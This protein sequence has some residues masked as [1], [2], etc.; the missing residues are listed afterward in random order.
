MDIDQFKT[1]NDTMGHP[2]GDELLFQALLQIIPAAGEY[3]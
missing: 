1:V 3:L 2:I